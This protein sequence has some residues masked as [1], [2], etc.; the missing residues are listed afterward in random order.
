[1]SRYS[2]WRAHL[3]ER[4]ARLT[5]E[6]VTYYPFEVFSAIVGLVIGLPLLVGLAAPTSLVV[7]LPNLVYWLYSVAMTLGA[8][9]TIAGL[10]HRSPMLLATGLQLSGGSYFVYGMATVIVA[11]L[12]TAWA[13]FGCFCGFGFVALIR[14]SHFRRLLDIQ[15]GA[16]RL[17]SR[18]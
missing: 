11:G 16:T 14:S 7:L 5:P 12:G 18:Q 13:A 1:M 2:E 15:R 10:R 6:V 3:R 8:A 4:V 17:R 9:T